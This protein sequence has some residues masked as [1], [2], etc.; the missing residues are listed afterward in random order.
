MN[1]L[2]TNITFA[3][4]GISHVLCICFDKSIQASYQQMIAACLQATVMSDIQMSPKF[5]QF[6]TQPE[7][8]GLSQLIISKITMKSS[9]D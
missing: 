7:F 4:N 2:F 8:H 1:T 9:P 6:V 3:H 5:K